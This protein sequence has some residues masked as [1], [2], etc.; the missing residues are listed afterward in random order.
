[1]TTS[2]PTPGS[3]HHVTVQ[4]TGAPADASAVIDA[5]LAT[6]TSPEGDSGGR[7]HAEDSVRPTVWTQVVDAAEPREAGQAT[8]LQGEVAAELS[9]GYQAVD[10]VAEALGKA[11]TAHDDGSASGDQ[12]TERHLRLTP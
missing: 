7:P 11:F 2:S 3:D 6:F 8:P 4:L 10:R 5:L 12:E 1:M 9:G